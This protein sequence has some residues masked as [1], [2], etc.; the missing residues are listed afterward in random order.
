MKLRRRWVGAGLGVLCGGTMLW[1]VTTV[2]GAN[3]VS[4][5]LCRTLGVLGVGELELELSQPLA[6][7]LHSKRGSFALAQGGLGVTWEEISMRRPQYQ[8]GQIVISKLLAQG[9][10]IDLPKSEPTPASSEDWLEQSYEVVRAD[11][12]GQLPSLRIDSLGLGGLRVRDHAKQLQVQLREG[13]AAL[14][15]HEGQL[16]LT[17]DLEKAQLLSQEI[18]RAHLD[19][20]W[21]PSKATIRAFE[22][23]AEAYQGSIQRLSLDA[24]NK[25]WQFENLDVRAKQ[26]AGLSQIDFRAQAPAGQLRGKLELAWPDDAFRV[27]S[28]LSGELGDLREVKLRAQTHC[29]PCGP[30]VQPWDIKLDGLGDLV[31]L[32]GQLSG[33]LRARDQKVDLELKGGQAKATALRLSWDSQDLAGVQ[34]DLRGRSHGAAR[35]SL[36]PLHQE[37]RCGLEA[38]AKDLYPKTRASLQGE[39]RASVAKG[40]RFTL[41]RLE[42][43][44]FGQRVAL[45]EEP[46]TIRYSTQGDLQVQSLDLFA[47][48][49]TARLQIS[50]TRNSAGQT[51][52][53]VQAKQWEL[54]LLSSFVPN[55]DLQGKLNLELDAGHDSTGVHGRAQGRIRRVKWRGL[56]W[57]NLR[58]SLDEQG[59]RT[60]IEGTLR[61]SRLAQAKFF[62]ELP[63]LAAGGEGSLLERREPWKGRLSI[64]RLRAPALRVLTGIEDLEGDIQAT[65]GTSGILARPQATL[66]ATWHQPRFRSLTQERVR[67]QAELGTNA[68]DLELSSVEKGKQTL[69]VASSLPLSR[70]LSALEVAWNKAAPL[71][72]E[73]STQSLN[74]AMLSAELPGIDVGGRLDSRI[75]LKGLPAEP[76]LGGW[77]SVDAPRYDKLKARDLTVALRHRGDASDLSLALLRGRGRIELDAHVPIE[78]DLGSSS[79]RWR[80][81]RHHELTLQLHQLDA[82]AFEG[83]V[84]VPKSVHAHGELHAKGT[85]EHHSVT[86]HVLVNSRAP[87]MA[88]LGLR[89]DFELNERRQNIEVLLRHKGKKLLSSKGRFSSNLFSIVEDT[90]RWKQIPARVQVQAKGV[91]L[92]ILEPWLGMALHA[93]SG[94][95]SVNARAKGVLSNLSWRGRASLQHGKIAIVPIEQRLKDI[96]AELVLSGHQVTLKTLS[97]RVG[98]GEM[99]LSGAMKLGVPD[100][101]RLSLRLRSVPLRI[102]GAPSLELSAQLESKL[103]ISPREIY[104]D[105]RLRNAEVQ[106]LELMTSD[107]KAIP[108]N[109]NLRFEDEVQIPR[110]RAS[111]AV[112]LPTLRVDTR[113]DGAVAVQGP[114]ISTRWTGFLNLRSP[115]G[116]PMYGEGTLAASPGGTLDILNNHFELSRARLD[117][118]KARGMLPLVDVR[119][120]TSVQGDTITVMAQGPANKPRVEFESTSNASRDQIVSALITGSTEQNA[121][122][123][124]RLLANAFSM[125]LMEKGGGIRRVTR[126]FGVDNVRFSFGDSLSDTIVSTGKWIN[127]KVYVE[128]RIRAEAPDDKSRVEGHVRYNFKKNWV[129][130]GYVGD[131][132]SGGG[133]LWWHRPAKAVPRGKA[134]D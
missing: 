36:E 67:L 130:E 71:R 73:L 68:L 24:E 11:W 56:K 70:G 13:Q 62:V 79:F 122:S 51:R 80:R 33:A 37:L 17:M 92:R 48:D 42:A 40:A 100:P 34:A 86:G 58:F 3:L 10:E 22:V 107:V 105:S 59:P 78:A 2:S 77:L 45:G 27:R 128:S 111:A 54:A 121:D 6:K 129:L 76:E 93:P 25:R 109:E 49:S 60:R 9:L 116:S 99:T 12:M 19:L 108:E 20:S 16:R 103:Q 75:S 44:A 7:G 8:D 47:R 117:F 120:T 53:R 32:E 63:K 115:S 84:D 87:K 30:L 83:L 91:D 28:E 123:K 106:V 38:G 4:G 118:S 29:E 88:S 113:I 119:A 131:R 14:N 41:N 95:L 18:G 31:A 104:L 97:A 46:A 126:R 69:R 39:L 124:G 66:V 112:A 96:H 98:A 21:V 90:A 15:L 114:M 35:C 101:G 134:Q 94:K 110:K 50:G 82:S 127:S 132:S 65:L 133:G 5:A 1:S 74:L 102:P 43:D 64:Q 26:V 81:D 52:A 57:G 55:L 85:R 89:T 72:A 125:M 61:G 23:Q